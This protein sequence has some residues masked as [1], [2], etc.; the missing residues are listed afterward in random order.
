VPPYVLPYTTLKKTSVY[1]PE[2]LLRRLKRLARSERT[3]EAE[4]LRRAIAAYAPERTSGGFALAR[5]ADGP[6]TSIADVPE[7]ELL[8]GFGS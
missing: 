2:P 8:Q 7:E 6:G 4:V 1:L 3:S 5:V